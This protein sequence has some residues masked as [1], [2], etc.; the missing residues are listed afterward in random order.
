MRLLIQIAAR[1]RSEHSGILA[2]MRIG[3]VLARFASL[4][5]PPQKAVRK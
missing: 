2:A 3:C 1:Q 4:M 5:T